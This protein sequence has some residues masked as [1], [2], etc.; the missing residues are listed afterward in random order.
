MYRGSAASV[1][2]CYEFSS[3]DVHVGLL[4]FT[5]HTSLAKVT[6][7]VNLDPRKVVRELAST[8]RIKS[9]YQAFLLLHLIRE[10]I[11]HYCRSQSHA[12]FP[13]IYARVQ[14][15]NLE[16]ICVEF[17]LVRATFKEPATLFH[18]SDKN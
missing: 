9:L 17:G 4:Y 10:Q 8:G 18:L 13:L 2:H 14:R 3:T 16:N 12:C 1:R 7:R 15:T 6:N 11:Q 5:D